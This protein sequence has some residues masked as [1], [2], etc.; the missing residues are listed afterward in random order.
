LL[1]KLDEHDDEY[2]EKKSAI[3]DVL[4]SVYAGKC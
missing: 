2:D 3:H 1:E 4:G